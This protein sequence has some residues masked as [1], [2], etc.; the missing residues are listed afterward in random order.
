MFD[1]CDDPTYLA[2][3][4]YVDDVL[5]LAGREPTRTDGMF[6]FRL[7]YFPVEF[8]SGFAKA[9]SFMRPGYTG[10]P[11]LKTLLKAEGLE[12]SR[13]AFL[14]RDAREN[15]GRQ[16]L[17]EGRTDVIKWFHE[18]AV[19]QVKQIAE[20]VFDHS[21]TESPVFVRGPSLKERLKRYIKRVV[22]Q[23]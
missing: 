13:K 23:V 2:Y 19:P 3:H 15:R 14:L 10:T 5:G 8:D 4:I 11:E 22:G 9:V 16:V 18:H 1:V 21:A 7:G 6:Y 17:L 20:A 12:R